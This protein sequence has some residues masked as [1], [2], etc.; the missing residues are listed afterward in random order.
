MTTKVTIDAHA[1]WPV[2]VVALDKKDAI[3]VQS[4]KIIV[5]PNTVQDFVVYD[6][7]QLLITELKKDDS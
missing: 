4:S 6:T 1:G 2:Q 5:A 3:W 7:R